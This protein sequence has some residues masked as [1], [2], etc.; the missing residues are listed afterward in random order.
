MDILKYCFGIDPAKHELEKIRR[1]NA[2]KRAKLKRRPIAQ[3]YIYV[4]AP[5]EQAPRAKTH[6]ENLNNLETAV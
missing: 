2:L 3:R 5:T 6:Q 1:T 4:H